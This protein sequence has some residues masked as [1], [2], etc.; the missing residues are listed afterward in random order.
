M[1]EG[2]SQ[3][4]GGQRGRADDAREDSYGGACG[5]L[6]CTPCRQGQAGFSHPGALAQPSQIGSSNLNGGAAKA[7]LPHKVCTTKPS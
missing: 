6:A 3:T 7:V 2:S 5:T 4:S 1:L